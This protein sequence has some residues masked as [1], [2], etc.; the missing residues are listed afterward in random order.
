MRLLIAVWL[1]IGI[2]IS[3]YS[4]PLLKQQI[5]AILETCELPP[6][7]DFLYHIAMVESHGGKYLTQFNGGP[8]RGY[9]QI[10][11]NT[12]ADILQNKDT[13]KLPENI[14][15]S[16]KLFE[17]ITVK[18]QEKI[19]TDNLVIQVILARIHLMRFREPIPTDLEG[20]AR[21]W[22]KF[23]NTPLGKGT[24]TKFIERNS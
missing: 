12:M 13:L 16:L 20:Q 22:K 10:Q 2:A 6:D 21:Y 24:I 7:H 4:E 14:R 15:Y 1:I 9:F 5:R 18:D 3:V 17:N 8:A 23:W 19:L 11:P